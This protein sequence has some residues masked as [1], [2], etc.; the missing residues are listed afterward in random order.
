MKKLFNKRRLKRSLSKLRLEI[1]RSL[2][3]LNSREMSPYDFHMA[4]FHVSNFSDNPHAGTAMLFNEQKIKFCLKQIGKIRKEV[5]NYY[6]YTDGKIKPEDLYM[7]CLYKK[8]L[9]TLGYEFKTKN[10]CEKF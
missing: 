1:L 9:N 2:K 6:Q 7:F 3:N 8:E 4:S 10:K 5:K